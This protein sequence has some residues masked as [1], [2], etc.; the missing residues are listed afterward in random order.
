M[1]AVAL[2]LITGAMAVILVRALRGPT[3]Q[4]RILAVNTFGTTTVLWLALY[5]FDT[6]ATDVVDI[7]MIYALTSF[8]ATIAVLKYVERGDLG[9]DP[10]DEG[11]Q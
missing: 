3:I 6:G 11:G 1:A 10:S 9:A 7:A 8:V 4:D 2:V 5:A